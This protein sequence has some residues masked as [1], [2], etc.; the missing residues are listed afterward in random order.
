MEE[1]ERVTLLFYQAKEKHSSLAPQELWSP[2]WWVGRS[3]IAQAAVSDKDIP[4]SVKLQKGGVADKVRVCAGSQV[5]GLWIF[6]F[7]SFFMS[8]SGPFNLASD[9]FI[10]VSPLI[11]NCSAFWTSEKVIEAGVWP[12]RSRGLK[13]LHGQEP[14]LASAPSLLFPS[15]SQS[16]LAGD[17]LGRTFL[18][19]ELL[20][21]FLSLCREGE[22]RESPSLHLLFCRYLLIKMTNIKVN[23]NLR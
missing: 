2:L 5:V 4:S 11:S 17:I 7:F 6:F 9:S 3:Y 13:C 20:F 23:H 21:E 8:L 10:A 19:I 15:K 1:E 12:T 22:F 18:T 14:C 16:S